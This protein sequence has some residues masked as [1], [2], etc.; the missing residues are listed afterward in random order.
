MKF[1]YTTGCKHSPI[2]CT[3]DDDSDM[4]HLKRRLVQT[5]FYHGLQD[6]HVDQAIALLAGSGEA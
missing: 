6:E 1:G 2:D 4:E 5:S 3:I